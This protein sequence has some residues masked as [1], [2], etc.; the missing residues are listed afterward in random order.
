M[1]DHLTDIS[2][3]TLPAH[4]YTRFNLTKDVRYIGLRFFGK[5]EEITNIEYLQHVLRHTTK[6]T[7][8]DFG[9]TIWSVIS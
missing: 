2:S 5:L 3:Q 8:D 9:H 6:N 7:T 1:N 4:I